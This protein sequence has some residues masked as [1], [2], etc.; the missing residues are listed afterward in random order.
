MRTAIVYVSCAG[1]YSSFSSISASFMIALS[2]PIIKSFAVNRH[3]DTL[4]PAGLLHID[5]V[6]SVSVL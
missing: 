6:A 2:M 3:A 1:R 4:F 5:M